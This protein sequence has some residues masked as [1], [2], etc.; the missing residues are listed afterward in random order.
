MTRLGSIQFISIQGKVSNLC[1]TSSLKV[2]DEVVVEEEDI[3]FNI[4][5]TAVLLVIFTHETR[6]QPVLGA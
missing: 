2:V 5:S 1:S 4:C 3:S 6:I